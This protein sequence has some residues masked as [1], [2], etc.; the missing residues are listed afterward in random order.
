L[1]GLRAQARREE[2]SVPGGRRIGV[3]VDDMSLSVWQADALRALDPAPTFY[4]YNCTNSR[5]GRRRL[6][7]LLYYLLNL[8]AIRNRMTRRVSFP[9]ELPVVGRRDFEAIAD[10][11]WEQLPEELLLGIAAD[12][13]DVIVKFGMGLLRVPPPDKLAAPILSYHHGDPEHFRGRPAGFYEMLKG[14]AVMGQVVQRLSNA[15]DSGAILASA[16]TKVLAHSYRA[17]LVEAYRHS[18]L[19]L[20]RAIANCLAGRSRVPAQWGP[21]YRLPGSWPVLRFV[22]RQWRN[23]AARLVYGLIKEKRWSVATANL[24]E[25]AGLEDLHETLVRPAE[26]QV[27]PR[28]AGYR[29]LA[30]PFLHP[31]DGLLVEAMS[32]R[33]CRGEVVHVRGT[34]ARRLSG[35]GG[36]YSYPATVREDDRWYVVPE[37]SDWSPAVAYPIEE[38]KLGEP[39]ALKLPGNPAVLDPTPFRHNGKFYIFANIAAEGASVLRLWFAERLGEPFVEHPA[40]PVRISPNGSR[41]AGCPFRIGGELVRFGQDFRGSYGDGLSAFKITDLDE[42]S[43]AE[44]PVGE[45]RFGH[46]R[47]PHTLNLG[48]GLAAF[49][50]YDERFSLLAGVRRWRERRAARRVGS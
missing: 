42:Q 5:P 45:L 3:I 33:S 38:G 44:Q 29:F 18:P 20:D 17:T 11:A 24:P 9:E 1:G 50:F 36:H 10:G 23:A 34:A 46:C 14:A 31:E 15:L 37:V 40:S 19:I 4:L 22:F 2:L 49:D 32:V 12:R 16:E 43:Y 21:N 8:V 48:R 25:H 27:V 13:P 39:I 6:R 47:G 28:I 35:R 30:D 7:H 41:M 26:W